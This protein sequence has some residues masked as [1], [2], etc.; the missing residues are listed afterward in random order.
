MRRVKFA[1]RYFLTSFFKR[2]LLINI[3]VTKTCNAFCSFC[4][5][6]L[7]SKNEER[8]N[9][10]SFIVKKLKPFTVSITGGEPLLRRDLE[11]IIREIKRAHWGCYVGVVTNGSLLNEKRA[12]SLRNAGLDQISISLDFPDGR[13][14]AN[15]GIPG[16]FKKIISIIPFLKTL[17]FYRISFNTV[18]TAQNLHDLIKIAEMARD[19]GIYVSF[20]TYSPA[21]TGERNLLPS[22]ESK[23]EISKIIGELMRFKKIHKNIMNSD[24]YLMKIPEYFSNGGIPNC[25]AGIKFLQVDPQGRLKRCSESL[26]EYD[27]ENFPGSFEPTDCTACWYSCRGETETRVNMRRIRE[28]WEQMIFK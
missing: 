3:E 18:I 23:E 24:E 28:L 13:H 12:S 26:P 20:S 25:K 16:L 11:D 15:R 17:D 21:K 6:Y 5:Y 14:D 7:T 1:I 8:L 9:D 22:P 19:M 10:Y 4:N 2:P 27:V